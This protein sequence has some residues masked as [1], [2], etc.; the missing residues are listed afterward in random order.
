MNLS[1]VKLRTLVL[2][3]TFVAAP[4]TACAPGMADG[5][6]EGEDISEANVGAVQL[7]LQ[8]IGG[9]TIDAVSY[10]ITGPGS[11]SKMGALTAEASLYLNGIPAGTGYTITMTGTASDTT[12][13]CMGTTK[14]DAVLNVTTPVKVHLICREKPSKAIVS[15]STTANVCPVIDTATASPSSLAVGYSVALTATAHDRDAAPSPLTYRWTTT[16][17]TLNNATAQDTSLTCVFV[18]IANITLTVSD[19]DTSAGCADTKTFSIT[20]TAP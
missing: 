19:G 9:L 13:V 4:A 1:V 5:K 6:G 12:T 10:F 8:L 18:G 15:V 3:V 11:Y 7:S 2:L 16:S 20:C 14:F 17:G